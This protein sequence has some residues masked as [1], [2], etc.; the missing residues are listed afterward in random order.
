MGGWVTYLP[1]ALWTYR[2]SLKSATGFSPFSLV[3]TIEVMSPAEV[4]TPSLRV[5]HMRKKEKEK[6]AFTA[7]RCEN[8]KG[9]DEK[10]RK[11]KSAATDMDKG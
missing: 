8:L 6:E 9:L 7:E 2:N 4:M 10:E 11:F 5:M 1:D 3:Y